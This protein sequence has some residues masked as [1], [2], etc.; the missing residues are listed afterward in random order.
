MIRFFLLLL[1]IFAA[2]AVAILWLKPDAGYVLINY[3]PW[4]AETT[5][6]VLVLGL[7]VWY[8]LFYVALKLFLAT[9]RLP[10][11]LRE[12]L[13][14]R[15][16]ERA[17]SSFETGL[18][19]LFEGNWKRAEG[20]LVRRAAD[21]HA[22]HL[23]YIA[24]ARAAQ[25]QGA[26]DRRDHYLQLAAQSK[27]ELEYTTLLA[28]ADLQRKRGE[29]EATRETAQ[30]LRARD[31]EHP[32]AVELLAES[33]AVL[34][35][36]EALRQL[37]ADTVQL[38]ALTAQRREEL[39]RRA[40]VELMRKAVAAARLDQLRALWEAAGPAR[41]HAELRREYVRGLARLN[42]DAEALALIAQTLA[43]DWDAE[44]AQLYGDLHTAD[45]IAQL[46]TAEQWLGRYG[47][48]PELLEIAGR[49]CLRNKLWGKARS[50]LEASLH[51]APTPRAYLDLAR[52]CEETQQREEAGRF[53]RLGLELAAQLR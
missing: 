50:Y 44:L 13:D 31:P 21:H 5:L 25:H 7:A 9:V 15:R 14:R 40:Y 49:V 47:E 35:D 41:G 6:A 28:R 30:V 29:F 4:V 22:A 20:E 43:Q 33:Y 2:G 24:A 34:G 46:A 52:L 26:A 32:F 10:G 11:N 17:R 18:Q 48:K 37:L 1:A 16:N 36:W 27:P 23:N 39:L 19:S 8:W 42:A 45:P 3:G 38:Q 51:A 53:Y 12:R